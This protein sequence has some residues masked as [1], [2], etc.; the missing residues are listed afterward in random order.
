MIHYLG[1]RA[2]KLPG[3]VDIALAASGLEEVPKGL[4]GHLSLY[5]NC[6]V[7]DRSVNNGLLHLLL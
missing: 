7:Y 1:R 3:R 6:L 2:D 4:H 5:S